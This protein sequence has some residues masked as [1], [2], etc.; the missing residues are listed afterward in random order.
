MEVPQA[1]FKGGGMFLTWAR[2]SELE[3]AETMREAIRRVRELVRRNGPAC[4]SSPSILDPQR[5][6]RA[7]GG[8]G[9]GEEEEGDWS[10]EPFGAF[11]PSS[12]PL[13][14]HV[15]GG[16]SWAGPSQA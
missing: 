14:A 5:A 6:A 1:E 2:L 7:I 9:A 10:E 15:N 12:S 8:G 13:D 11:G 16:S 4:S 3:R